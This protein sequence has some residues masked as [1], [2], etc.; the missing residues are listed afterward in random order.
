MDTD[1]DVDSSAC[2][3]DNDEFVNTIQ[4]ITFK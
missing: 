4:D 2:G 3:E 1:D